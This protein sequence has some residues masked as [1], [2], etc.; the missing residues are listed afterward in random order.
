MRLSSIAFAAVSLLHSCIANNVAVMAEPVILPKAGVARQVATFP[1]VGLPSSTA[2]SP[3]ATTPILF[4]TTSNTQFTTCDSVD[5]TWE[6]S[7]PGESITLTVT[8]INVTQ[9]DPP[10]SSV[11]SG[12]VF[13][14]FTDRGG[15]DDNDSDEQEHE[16]E[17]EDNGGLGRRGVNGIPTGVS[18]TSISSSPNPDGP[19]YLLSTLST[20]VSPSAELFN[21]QQVYVPQGW[22]RIIATATNPQTQEYENFVANSA[23]FFVS[24]GTDTSCLITSGGSTG[25]GSGSS[26]TPGSGAGAGSQT[27]TSA[28]DGGST[29]VSSPVGSSSS[30]SN[31]GAIAGGVIGGLAFL[32]LAAIGF[33]FLRRRAAS[34]R[35]RGAVS[36]KGDGDAPNNNATRGIG[37]ILS[38]GKWGKLGSFEGGSGSGTRNRS[39]S[40]GAAEAGVLAASN[41][42]PGSPNKRSSSRPGTGNSICS[43]RKRSL[44]NSNNSSASGGFG[45]GLAALGFANSQ[46]KNT[47]KSSNPYTAAAKRD[48]RRTHESLGSVGPMLGGATSSFSSTGHGSQLQSTGSYGAGYSL[49]G[50]EEDYL[51]SATPIS[52]SPY[53]EKEKGIPMSPIHSPGS[54]VDYYS[55][56]QGHGK[57]PFSDPGHIIGAAGDVSSSSSPSVSRTNSRRSASRP[58]H[59]IS[60]GVAGVG[61]GTLGTIGGYSSE[62]SSSINQSV[63]NSAVTHKTTS[64]SGARARAQSSPMVAPPKSPFRTR[65][66]SPSSPNSP[67]GMGLGIGYASSRT[68]KSGQRRE[69]EREPD[70]SHYS[71]HSSSRRASSPD[72]TKAYGQHYG[73]NGNGRSPG[74]GGGISPPSLPTIPG[75]GFSHSKSQSQ[76]GIPTSPGRADASSPPPGV[77]AGSTSKRKTPRK[78]VPSYNP[79]D[80]LFNAYQSQSPPQSPPGSPR[81]HG[82]ELGSFSLSNPSLGISSSSSSASPIASSLAQNPDPNLDSVSLGNNNNSSSSIVGVA[83]RR[84]PP[85]AALEHKDSYASLKSL[86]E[87]GGGGKPMHVLIPDMPIEQQGR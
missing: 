2:T 72:Y 37:G 3:P 14:T 18:T 77:G 7:G 23:S 56:S 32:A 1:T 21:W 38:L 41:L 31:S 53:D 20:S 83:Q 8:N 9:Q 74:G 45:I 76:S 17:N 39:L 69:Q 81:V 33:I 12:G 25:S 49:G 19:P 79:E 55:T 51:Y 59:S 10:T 11:F 60:A 28:G 35:M 5:I 73:N 26:T 46:K 13:N 4:F 87:L 40:T 78:P 84:I 71:T 30:S 65:S 61:A 86:R 54:S 80:P 66:G 44:S 64:T 68:G 6:F 22:Y 58:N 34:G 67:V 36:S 63:A 43:S 29:D 15:D 52:S 57:S 75:S 24:N 82:Q 70:Q 62:S 47:K 85:P 50:P 42:P 48:R 16:N 27:Q